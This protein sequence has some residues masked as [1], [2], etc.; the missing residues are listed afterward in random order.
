MK[1]FCYQG[2]EHDC[3]FAALKMLFSIISKNQNYLYLPK[4]SHSEPYSLLDLIEIAATHQ[5]NLSGYELE[6]KKLPEQRFPCLVEVNEKHMVVVTKY[7]KPYFYVSDPARGKL[8][9]RYDE[10]QKIYAGHALLIESEELDR[11]FK[12]EKPRLMPISYG[13]VHAVVASV[14]IAML[15]LDFYLMN[16]SENVPFI[17]MLIMFLIMVEVFENWYLLKMSDYFDNRYIPLFF[18][19]ESHQNQDDYKKFLG[20]KVSLFQSSKSIVVFAS[21]AIIL[22]VLVSINE[23]KNLLVIALIAIYK[24]LEKYLTQKKDDETVKEMSRQ[25]TVAFNNKDKAVNQLLS[26]NKKS[27]QFGMV[28]TTRNCFFQLI[29]MLL[30]L[31]M[32]VLS[33]NMSAN[34]AVF[35]FGIYFIIGQGISLIV[36]RLTDHQEQQKNLAQFYDKCGL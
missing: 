14:L 8:K 33:N 32:M 25:E 7:K 20:I 18:R 13:I 4:G 36:N 23:P 15:G 27:N 12:A 11:K 16:L 31:F 35:H 26:L 9:M 10:L 34:Y 5:V 1:N 17:F 19:K 29:L 2:S 28:I 3:G 21:L 30:T 22:G 24:S 6:F